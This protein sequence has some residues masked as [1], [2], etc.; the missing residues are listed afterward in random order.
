P[1]TPLFRSISAIAR[2]SPISRARPEVAPPP[3]GWSTLIARSTPSNVSVARNTDALAPVPSVPVSTKRPPSRVP[4]LSESRSSGIQL[5]RTTHYRRGR[6]AQGMRTRG[7][8][9][10]LQIED[11][12]TGEG[13]E[14][15]NRQHVT[16]HYT[17][18]LQ[19]GTKFD[20]SHDRGRPLTFALGERRVIPG[21]DHGVLGMRVGGKRKLTI[22]PHLAYG[23]RGVPDV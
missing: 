18:W 11:L 3:C 23:A 20:S 15:V 4:R 5:P 2:A 10:Q 12:V 19:D 8:A 13:A 16:V 9:M 1:S 22:P 21:W 14:A 17:G 6:G 7:G